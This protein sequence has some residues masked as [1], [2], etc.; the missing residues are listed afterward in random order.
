MTVRRSVADLMDAGLLYRRQGVGTFIAQPHLDRDHTRL[1]GLAEG[2][3][4][5]GL[6]LSVRVLAADVLPAKSKVARSLSLKERELVVR[7]R[8]LH[9]AAGAPIAVHESCAPYALFP[10]LL[11]EDLKSQYVWEVLESHGFR[12]RRAV[13]RVDAREVHG[14]IAHLLKLDDG[15][16]ILYKER[17]VYLDDGTPVEFTCC[18]NRGDM[19]SITSVLSR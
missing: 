18:H 15:A 11:Q 2:G 6:R 9:L 16:P 14:E 17:I 5:G 7:L 12:V 13:Q 8:T 19:Y 4:D 10:Q 1:S 3:Q